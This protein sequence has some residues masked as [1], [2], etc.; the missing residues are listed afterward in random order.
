MQEGAIAVIALFVA[1]EG[2]TIFGSSILSSENTVAVR[3]A[4]HSSDTGGG[5]DLPCEGNVDTNTLVRVAARFSL[6]YND[7]L[8]IT[9]LTKV[10]PP[11]EC[12]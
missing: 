9:I 1:E 4:V 2:G 3:R 12:L 10:V 7:L 8:N 11:T 6:A 5:V